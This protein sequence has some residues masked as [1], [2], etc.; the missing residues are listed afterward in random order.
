MFKRPNCVK[1]LVRRGVP[2]HFRTI[3]W[4]LM[5]GTSGVAIHERYTE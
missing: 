3:V 5:A 1:E 4:Q 2:Q